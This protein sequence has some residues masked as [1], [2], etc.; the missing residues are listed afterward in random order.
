M[1]KVSRLTK[2]ALA[3]KNL[4]R[5]AQA[6][7]VCYQ[8]NKALGEIFDKDFCKNIEVVSFKNEILYI[9][10]TSPSYSQEIKIKES[11]IIGAING[12]LEKKTVVEKVKFRSGN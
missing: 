9:K 5:A 12:F 10:T 2:N 11:A 7:L 1:E 6:A 4:N 8:A 3:S